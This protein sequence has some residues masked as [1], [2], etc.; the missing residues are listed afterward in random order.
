MIGE[1]SRLTNR[2]TS[3]DEEGDTRRSGKGELSYLL[4]GVLLES[5]VEWLSSL[6]LVIH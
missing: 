2:R 4:N 6:S 1:G 5:N 3:S